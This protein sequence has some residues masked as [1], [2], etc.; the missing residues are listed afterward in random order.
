MQGVVQILFLLTI[1]PISFQVLTAFP[2]AVKGI[3]IQGAASMWTFQIPAYFSIWQN[4][5]RIS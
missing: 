2:S 3:L 4:L 1:I 5:C